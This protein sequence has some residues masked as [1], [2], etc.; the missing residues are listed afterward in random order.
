MPGCQVG[1]VPIMRMYGVTMDGNSVCCH[2]HGFAP[3]FFVLAPPGF[4]ESHCAP[5]REALNKVVMNDLRSNREQIKEAVLTVEI[6]MKQNIM[7]YR[8]E[9][10]TMFIRITVALPRLIAPCKRLLDRELVYPPLGQHHYQCFESNIDFDIRFMVDSNVVGCSWIELPPGEWR[11][12][13]KNSYSGLE[14]TSRCQL[15][16]DVACDKFIAHQPE[17]E[18]SKVAPFR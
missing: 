16:V 8:G 18:W 17:G 9:E 2:V 4:N 11:L 15:E 5:F 3:Y 6:V 1:P 13:T 10:K 7:G 12:R 14:L